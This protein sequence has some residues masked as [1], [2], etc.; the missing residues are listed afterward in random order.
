MG[1]QAQERASRPKAPKGSHP[2]PRHQPYRHVATMRRY[3]APNSVSRSAQVE[4]SGTPIW[5]VNV[6]AWGARAPAPARYDRNA[7]N[8][9]AAVCIAAT[10]CYWL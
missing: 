3:K 6:S 8:F 5:T 7:A 2:P 4:G 10:I 9:L 1:R